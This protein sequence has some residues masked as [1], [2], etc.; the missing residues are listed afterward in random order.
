ME[1]QPLV[2]PSDQWIFPDNPDTFLETAT[3]NRL[4]T[5]ISSHQKTIKNSGKMAEK[6]LHVAELISHHFSHPIT[7]AVWPGCDVGAKTN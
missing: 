2:R 6:N 3:A 4:S 7:R 1:Q 5:W